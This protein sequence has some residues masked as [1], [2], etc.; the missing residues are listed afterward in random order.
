M[1]TP[2]HRTVR[3][4]RSLADHARRGRRQPWGVP[5]PSSTDRFRLLSAPATA[6]VTVHGD[7]APF[8]STG[9]LTLPITGVQTSGQAG[10]ARL[11]DGGVLPILTGIDL[12]VAAGDHVAVVGPRPRGSA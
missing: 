2:A 1:G 10:R 8:P 12:T 3:L 11:P 5:R 7:P 4:W 6:D 9:L